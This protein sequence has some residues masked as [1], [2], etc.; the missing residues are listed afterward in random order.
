MN[1]HLELLQWCIDNESEH[2]PISYN[3]NIGMS[4]IQALGGDIAIN[5]IEEG[6][7]DE[8]ILQLGAAK[9]GNTPDSIKEKRKQE[10]LKELAEL[11]GEK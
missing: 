3:F 8:V 1:K 5:C 7:I 10:L 2:F 6:D 11:E 4:W 9:A